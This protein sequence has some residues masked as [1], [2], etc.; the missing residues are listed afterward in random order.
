MDQ[1]LWIVCILLTS[2][3]VYRS[4]VNECPDDQEDPG[5]WD[6]WLLDDD[7][8]YRCIRKY[9]D[10]EAGQGENVT[11]FERGGAVESEYEDDE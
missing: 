3:R 9:Y 5:S 8:T 10:T 6:T 4:V 7:R 11:I 2:L 1:T